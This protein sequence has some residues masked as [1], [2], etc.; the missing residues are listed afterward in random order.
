MSFSWRQTVTHALSAALPPRGAF[1]EIMMSMRTSAA[2]AAIVGGAML[3]F[4]MT[5]ASAFTLSGPS[6]AQPVAAAQID[7]VWWR[8]GWGGGWGYGGWG[9]G[10]RGGY[11]GPGYRHCWRG[12]YG[13]LHCGW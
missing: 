12:Y 2:V 9:Y 4:S 10:W 13:R 11:W 3:A 5:P 7:H 8:G 6:L 1:L